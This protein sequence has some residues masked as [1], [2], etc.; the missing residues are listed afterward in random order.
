MYF[1]TVCY[2][3]L[4]LFSLLWIQYCAILY[5]MMTTVVTMMMMM[6]V[7]WSVGKMLAL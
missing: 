5:D 3:Y 4:S 7:M 2:E 6:M 1:T